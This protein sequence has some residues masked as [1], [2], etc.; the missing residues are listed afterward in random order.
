MLR[1][2]LLIEETAKSK[3]SDIFLR[4]IHNI[5]YIMLVFSRYFAFIFPQTFYHSLIRFPEANE[6][7]L[8]LLENDAYIEIDPRSKWLNFELNFS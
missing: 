3:H 1:M 5:S 4:M 8:L 7:V 2:N 6:T